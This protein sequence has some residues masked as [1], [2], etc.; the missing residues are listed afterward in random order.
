[1]KKRTTITIH[2]DLYAK[3]Q[4]LMSAAHFSDFSTFVEHLIRQESH[5][6]L[7]LNE[8]PPLPV[9]ASKPVKYSEGARVKGA[10][11]RVHPADKESGSAAS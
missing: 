1:M 3:A 7:A 9:P 5:S 4:E 2:P 6:N 11:F 8:P 10:R